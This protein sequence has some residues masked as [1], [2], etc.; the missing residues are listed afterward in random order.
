MYLQNNTRAGAISLRLGL[1][2]V[3]A[4]LVCYMGVGKA[5]KA[6]GKRIIKYNLKQ[7]YTDFSK[8]LNMMDLDASKMSCFYSSDP[9]T[10]SSATDCNAFYKRFGNTIHV[11]QYCKENAYEEG[12]VPKY[13]EYSTD[14]NCIGYSEQMINKYDP[15]FVLNNNSIVIIY[16]YGKNNPMPIF[17]IDINGKLPPNRAGQ[18]LF[19]FVVMRNATGDYYFH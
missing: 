2:I 5:A 16:N 15:V 4:F 10:P 11:M 19:S 14:Q 9:N 18:D 3:L 12:C 7:T 8:A 17:A 1:L 6:I 13:K